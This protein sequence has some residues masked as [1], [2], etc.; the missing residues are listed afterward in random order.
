MRCKACNCKL[1][2][3]ELMSKNKHGIF[4]ELCRFCINLAFDRGNGPVVA[5]IQVPLLDGLARGPSQYDD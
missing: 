1:K 4:E 5:H 2:D 3:H